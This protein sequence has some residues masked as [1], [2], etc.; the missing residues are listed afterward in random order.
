[1]GLRLCGL[2]DPVVQNRPGCED[3]ITP[4]SEERLMATLDIFV[5]FEFD[6][7]RDLRDSFY[8]QARL[9]TQH[10]SQE[11]LAQR[12]VP[13][14]GME[15]GG[16]GGDSRVRCG[17]RPDWRGHPQRSGSQDRSGH[18]PELRQA[19]FPGQTAEATLHGVS[20]DWRPYPLEMA[21]NQQTTGQD[22]SP[23]SP[24]IE[25]LKL[26]Q[27]IVN[28]LGR[29]SFAIKSAAAAVAAGLVALTTS[30][31]TPVPPLPGL[32]FFHYGFSMRASL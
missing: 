4:I 1:M 11:L 15:T 16:E 10:R 20:W 14:G 28:R 21:E 19:Y 31:S 30:T 18:G 9:Q 26:I 17:D 13:Y 29:N 27:A 12:G 25:H 32:R 5:S 8:E 7:D 2:R 3:G 22:M 24:G 23:R 6:K